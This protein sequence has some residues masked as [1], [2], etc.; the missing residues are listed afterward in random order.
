MTDVQQVGSPP[1]QKR[2][3]KQKHKR[4][5]D[6]ARKQPD[7]AQIKYDD[8]AIAEGKRLVKAL[9][10]NE[11]KLG[12]LADRLEP[13]YGDQTLACFAI[14]IGVKVG[15]LNRCRSVYRAYKGRDSGSGASFAVRKA[16]QGHPERDK[17][18]KEVKPGV[19]EAR[20]IM[21]DYRV[22]QGQDPDKGQEQDQAQEQDEW[23][24]RLRNLEPQLRWKVIEA[25]RFL[26]EA[27][28]FALDAHKKYG[29][30]KLEH[31]DLNI[32]CYAV[33][34]PDKLVTT[35]RLGGQAANIVTNTLA[36]EIECALTTPPALLPPPMF[37]DKATSDEA[38][39]GDGSLDEDTPDNTTPD[40]TT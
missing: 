40:Q 31:L 38:A 36:D 39:S 20:T 23:L 7:K 22:A 13:I 12:E 33:D 27:K 29:H 18:I 34:E 25:R 9:Q 11:M 4:K 10:S 5:R 14:E 32:L 1:K 15:T 24:E 30:L 3:Q 21:K 17:I 37:D 2:K 35:L 28:K 19:R 16:L 26:D 6:R 8:K